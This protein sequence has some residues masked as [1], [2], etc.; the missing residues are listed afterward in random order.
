MI[1]RLTCD[2][3]CVYVHAADTSL[4]TTKAFTHGT[5]VFNE[6]TRTVVFGSLDSVAIPDNLQ[7][8]AGNTLQLQLVAP[9]G[10]LRKQTRSG[11][12]TANEK[13]P[14]L[15]RIAGMAKTKRKFSAEDGWKNEIYKYRAYFTH[16][17]IC[18][19]NND[20]FE[21]NVNLPHP[22][23]LPQW[24]NDCIGRQK[25]LWNRLA[26]LCRDARRKCSPA[27]TKEII[28]FVNNTILPEIDAFNLMLGRARTKE[29]I[30]HP[31]KLKVEMPSIDGLW[32]F[33]GELR[34]RIEKGR[35]VPD[36]LLEKVVGFSEQFKAE[37]TPL[38]E[39]MNN[40]PAI[41]EREAV[42]LGLKR[43]EIRPTVGAF[44]AVLDR[45]K[46]TKPLWS[47]GWPLLKYPD[48]P[49]SANWGVHYYFNKAGIDSTLLESGNGVPGLNFGRPLP[50]FKTGHDGIKG[51]RIHRMMREAIISIPGD[52][53]DKTR[54]DFHFAVLQHREL[55]PNSHL[56]EWKLIYQNGKL[57]LCLVV[58][59]QRPLPKPALL[60]A[61]LEIGWRR[62]EEGIRFATLYEPATKTISEAIIDFQRSPRDNSN[63]TA[64]HI[65]LGPTRWEKRH[66]TALHPKWKPKDAIPGIIETRMELSARCDYLKDTAKILLRKH[67]GE[68]VP[69]WLEKAGSNGLHKVAQ[70]FMDDPAVLEIVNEWEEKNR[71]IRK[72]T[73]IYFDQ[74]TKR[75]EYGHAQVAH[76]ICRYLQTKGIERLIVEDSF[77]SKVAQR[78]NNEDPESLKR[79]QKYRQFAA[80]AK[81]ISLV[82]NTAVKYAITVDTGEN[83][84]LTRRC[85]YCDHLNQSTEKEKYNCEGCG[86]EIKQ[87]HNTAINLVRFDSDPDL[88]QKALQDGS[89]A[90]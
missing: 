68:R 13:Q 61:G 52:G 71:E 78:H 57:W 30:R 21:P 50:P 4:K 14:G 15:L 3:A 82:R 16:P 90:Q 81:F 48:S 75:V 11:T 5:L 25:A 62:T 22:P 29:K 35:A 73:A 8:C 18:T 31:S 54:H 24:L 1:A 59:L 10:T 34:G 26:W 56:K 69:P 49:K 83:I 74:T 77:L 72:L 55:P 84:N 79:S 6:E 64:F 2:S 23:H 47:E 36:G 51:K 12:L 63:R 58:E 46:T 44:K 33:V 60:S 28:E 70:E 43:F 39:F 88:A 38:N 37:Y 27:P 76:D 7:L 87:D 19:D 42:A 67:L 32:S 66:I 41:A 17:G 85:H 40:F 89:K 86:R 45:R 65:D 9:D 53:T 20:K 80:L